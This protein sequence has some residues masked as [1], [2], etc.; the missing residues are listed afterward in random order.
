MDDARDPTLMP[1][2]KDHFRSRGYV[3]EL[4]KPRFVLLTVVISRDFQ[5][6]TCLSAVRLFTELEVSRGA[7]GICILD[8]ARALDLVHIHT[9]T[10]VVGQQLAL[11]AS[12]SVPA[13]NPGASEVAGISVRMGTVA[14]HCSHPFI[15]TSLFVT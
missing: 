3:S 10:V 8:C 13:P 12:A 9:R 6:D 7:A 14:A 2:K 5:S 4:L 15:F 11:I 1:S